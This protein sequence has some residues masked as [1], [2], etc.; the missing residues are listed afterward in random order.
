MH[1]ASILSVVLMVGGVAYGKTWKGHADL[2]NSQGEKI[3]TAKLSP[4]TKGVKIEITASK[5]PP[6]EHAFHIHAAGKCDAPDFKT[7]EGH[8]NPE[9]KKHGI[10]NPDG[11]HAGD[12]QNVTVKPDGTLKVTVVDPNVNLPEGKDSLFQP[13][14]TALVIHEKPDDNVTDPAGNAGARIACG[15]INKS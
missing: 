3:G 1:R 13:A 9:G 10:N 11:P 6:G 2:I 4:A 5:L 12:M 15:V 14:G 7:A 8:F